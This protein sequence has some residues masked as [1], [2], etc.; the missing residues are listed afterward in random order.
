MGPAMEELAQAKA[1]RLRQPVSALA[2]RRPY[3]LVDFATVICA[4]AAA[5]VDVRE[6]AK[7]AVAQGYDT[8]SCKLHVYLRRLLRNDARFVQ[9]GRHAWTLASA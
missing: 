6:I 3:A 4:E 1:A 5:A 2:N 9:R 8:Q 7:C